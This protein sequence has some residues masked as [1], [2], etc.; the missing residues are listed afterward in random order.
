MLGKYWFD[1]LGASFLPVMKV[2]FLYIIMLKLDINSFG[3]RVSVRETNRDTH[4]HTHRKRERERERDCCSY[5]QFSYLV[6]SNSLRPHG[7]QHARLPCPSPTPG[8]CSN[9]CPASWWC[10][11]TVSSS[12]IPLSSCLK[13]FPASGSFPMSQFF[14]SGGQSYE[15]GNWSTEKG[16]LN[17]PWACA[18]DLSSK[19]TL[20]VMKCLGSFRNLLP[21]PGL[22]R[23]NSDDCYPLCF[24]RVWWNNCKRLLHG[25][26]LKSFN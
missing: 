6:V 4:T 16:W 26:S 19:V 12:V 14:A 15:G 17:V 9:S 3:L 22:L 24:C 5:V 1:S 23:V 25:V 7:L 13:S 21:F 18:P 2:A 8:A 10:R 11:P 20:A